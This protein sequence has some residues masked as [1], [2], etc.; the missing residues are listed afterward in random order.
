MQDYNIKSEQS[1]VAL[2]PTLEPAIE[3]TGVYEPE[4]PGP[5]IL[6]P[7]KWLFLSLS[8][9]PGWG[10]KQFFKGF[11]LNLITRQGKTVRGPRMELSIQASKA[12][13][14]NGLVATYDKN[15]S[16]IWQRC[17]DEFRMLNDDTIIGMSHF[18]LPGVRGMQVMF[19][20]HRN[21]AHK[22]V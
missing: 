18:N 3:L 8:G 6:K 4:L 21:A 17:T 1:L 7:F 20:L 5:S 22:G 2:F 16:F 13:G 9:L 11:A 15:A 14:K 12:D 10:G 19:V